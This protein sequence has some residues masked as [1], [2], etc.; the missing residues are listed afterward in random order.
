MTLQS[1]SSTQ[2]VQGV[3]FKPFHVAVN[4]NLRRHVF[5]FNL[6]NSISGKKKKSIPQAS[7]PLAGRSLL[8]P[9][10]PEALF[11]LLGCSSIGWDTLGVLAGILT[12]T[13]GGIPR[14]HPGTSTRISRFCLLPRRPNRSHSTSCNPSAAQRSAVIK[15]VYLLGYPCP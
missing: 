3:S 2:A 14:F 15:C 11:L 6:E 12:Q 7:V 9:G 4:E 1:F 8:N 13:R 10:L 5:I